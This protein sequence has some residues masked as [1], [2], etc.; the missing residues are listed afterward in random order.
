MAKALVV[1]HEKCNGCRKCEEVCS[2]RHGGVANPLS[3]RIRIMEWQPEGVFMPVVCHQ[4]EDAP[5]IAACP[6]MA[7]VRDEETG[8]TSVDYDRCISCKTCVAVCPFG[9]SRY[10]PLSKRVVTCDLCDGDPQCVKACE[11]GA[12]T[13]LEKR[14]IN[15][16]RQYEAALKLYGAADRALRG[17]MART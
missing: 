6:T 10:D 11:T 7:R 8:K 14:D 9:A 3:S 13:C 2:A 1:N 17:K 15:K 4:C 16:V 5:C 12:I